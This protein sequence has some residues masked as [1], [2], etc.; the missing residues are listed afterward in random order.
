MQLQLGD[1]K[2]FFARP[3]LQHIMLQLWR[4][5][6]PDS[7]QRSTT[8]RL[9]VSLRLLC[10]SIPNLLLLPCWAFLPFIEDRLNE[11]SIRLADS[12]RQAEAKHWEAKRKARM[13]ASPGSNG[14]PCL[15]GNRQCWNEIAFEHAV[16]EE[17]CRK[18]FQ[19]QSSMPL[20]IPCNKKYLAILTNLLFV[21]YLIVEDPDGA[22]V[23]SVLILSAGAWLGEVRQ[24]FAF[25]GSSGAGA[26]HSLSFWF[27]DRVNVMELTA[28]LGRSWQ[29]LMQK[30]FSLG[31]R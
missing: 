26:S 29:M 1:A 15:V 20:L 2:L 14:W 18:V 23:V 8:K 10:Y 4:G 22:N 9:Q 19:I 17:C 25:A 7:W 16:K 28:C 24:L 12:G 5:V 27:M 3:T 6:R 11:V 21:A 31:R 13:A 30:V